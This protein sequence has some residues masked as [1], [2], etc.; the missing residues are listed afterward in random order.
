MQVSWLLSPETLGI[1]PRKLLGKTQSTCLPAWYRLQPVWYMASSA[2]LGAVGILL[3]VL[4]PWARV[5]V[6]SDWGWTSFGVSWLIQGAVSWLA[7]VSHLGH[8]SMWHVVDNRCA[9]VN[10]VWTTTYGFAWTFGASH[11]GFALRSSNMLLRLML[12]ALGL[13]FA[14]AALHGKMLSGRAQRGRDA[15][16]FFKY[17]AQWHYS[18]SLGLCTPLLDGLL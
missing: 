15:H 11:F 12:R 5:R 9:C 3:I 18:L 1:N 2:T 13:G 6:G 4:A 7:D 16:G 8:T 17:H 10:L 14:F